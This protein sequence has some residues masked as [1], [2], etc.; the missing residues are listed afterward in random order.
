MRR[1]LSRWTSSL[2]FAAALAGATASQAAS[3]F[4]LDMPAQS[5]SVTL[6]RVARAG[7]VE[8]A[9]DR[10][11]TDRLRAP[12]LKG[13][14]TAD[15]ALAA[16]LA[17]SGLSVQRTRDGAYVVKPAS[18]PPVLKP[19][20]EGDGAVSEILVLGRRNLNTGI[21][22]TRDDI[23]PYDMALDD[24]IRTA[25]A[26]DIEGFLRRAMPA[27][28][29]SASLAQAPVANAASA[30]S[31]IDLLGLGGG[32]TLVLVDGRRLP[33][34]PDAV[35]NGA[36]F[37]QADINGIPLAAVQRI[38]VL[39]AAA[40]ALHGAGA[41]GGVVN[42]ILKRDYQ[43]AEVGVTQGFTQHGGGLASRLDASIGRTSRDGRGG[44]S[45]RIGLAKDEGLDVG[46]RGFGERALLTN[47]AD[48]AAGKIIAPY[49]PVGAAVNVASAAGVLTL[50]PA[51]GGASLGSAYTHF[52]LSG[53]TAA[54]VVANAGKL[55]LEL[56]AD[57]FG[58]T[59]SL[60]TRTL[61]RSLIVSARQE[62]G[63]LEGFFDYL[64]LDNRGR[65]LAP[66]GYAIL[67]LS[68]NSAYNPFEQ[69]IYVSRSVP[70]DGLIRNRSASQRATAGLIARLPK[71]WMVEGDFGLSRSQVKVTNDARGAIVNATLATAYDGYAGP[72][73]S[74]FASQDEFLA[75]YR[76]YQVANTA[77]MKQG[78]TLADLNLRASGP[79]WR[80]PGGPLTMTVTAEA[81]RE[82]TSGGESFAFDV[83]SQAPLTVRGARLRLTTRSAS[84]E[85]RAPLGAPDAPWL[86][87]GLELQAAVRGD[88]Y[89]MTAPQT[90]SSL[91]GDGAPPVT[92]QAVSEHT[93]LARTL[94]LK[95]FAADGVMLRAS[96]SEGHLP[97]RSDQAQ[98]LVLSVRS[99][100]RTDPRRG[101]EI[102]G[103]AGPLTIIQNGS[104]KLDPERARTYSLGVVV[105]PR[106]LSG[107]RLSVDYLRTAKSHEI[108]TFAAGDV[109]YF[110]AREA[111]YPTRVIRAPMTDADR[112]NGY[113]VGAVTLIDTSAL[114]SGRSVVETLD[115]SAE[116]RR[117]VRKGSV[118]GYLRGLW[119]PSY[120]RIAD[121][122]K[123]W[124]E[125]AGY[126]DGPLRFRALAGGQ[127]TNDALSLGLNAQYYGRYRVAASGF[128]AAPVNLAIAQPHGSRIASQV[129]LDAFAG[130]SIGGRTHVQA[131]VHNL[132]DATPPLALA[133]PTGYSTYGDARERSFQISLTRRF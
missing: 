36:G 89:R 57:A 52:A 84:A 120:R 43:G 72:G 54:E 132:L 99:W 86:L 28:A 88:A 92:L 9:F 4:A 105:E 103:A 2:A 94:G 71:G 101:G 121:P 133:A 10:A 106:W 109:A 30:R 125:T 58:E 116:Y 32:Q 127:W 110:L 48:F 19:K 26:S 35:G 64:F 82:R 27:N 65:A 5:L 60:T 126:S 22:R 91:L 63:I 37:V 1:R 31:R 7:S 8:L 117:T 129:Y 73:L 119:L 102:L 100:P 80:L 70:W 98:S 53:F 74:P 115:V 81:A 46:E 56:P 131:I 47:G 112:A 79:L 69:S 34:V 45:M 38:E 107:A 39:T 17:A 93:V 78:D 114:N 13:Q 108:T 3:S 122:E 113:A 66:A 68:A 55:N 124:I 41:T 95:T 11:V 6:N 49:V 77:F 83:A 75:A 87:R 44:V 130:W 33:S 62:V 67:S 118:S 90:H 14:F 59:Q 25:G 18:T 128:T 97:P 96:Y 123:P 111:R 12:R 23:Q 51:Y 20:D 61:R 24:T 104:P 85:W 50:K 16:A 21:R 29:Q 42:I 76:A 15:Q 40:G